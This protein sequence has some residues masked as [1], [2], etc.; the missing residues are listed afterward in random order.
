MFPS[1][2]TSVLLPLLHQNVSSEDMPNPLALDECHTMYPLG[3]SPSSQNSDNLPNGP[4]TMSDRILLPDGTVL[5]VGGA[6]IGSGGG[7]QLTEPPS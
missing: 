6:R 7:F 2:A 3:T 1:S 4:H 5:L